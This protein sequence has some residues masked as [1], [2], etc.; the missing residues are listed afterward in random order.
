MGKS[1]ESNCSNR[2]NHVNFLQGSDDQWF[3]IK[4]FEWK[5]NNI[6]LVLWYR[7]SII[8]HQPSNIF[9]GMNKCRRGTVTFSKIFQYFDEKSAETCNMFK[10]KTASKE[11]WKGLLFLC[12]PKNSHYF[13]PIWVENWY[14]KTVLVCSILTLKV[15]FLLHD[16]TGK[17]AE[18]AGRLIKWAENVRICGKKSFLC[19]P[20]LLLM[21][22]RTL[23]F[24]RC[25]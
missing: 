15:E 11:V 7:L 17:I 2:S 8:I 5:P 16:S 10:V 9:D 20:T 14:T 24:S 3:F 4:R 21:F 12:F 13:V 18:N 23:L 25:I 19:V 1:D 22:L 6:E